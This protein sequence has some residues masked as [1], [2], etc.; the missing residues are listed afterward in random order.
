M[1]RD[2]MENLKRTMTEKNA[3]AR[4]LAV[5][6]GKGG[7]GKTNI[8]VNLAICLAASGQRVALVDA[9]MGLG[10]LDIIMNLQSRYNISHVISGQKQLDQITCIGPGDVEVICGASGLESLA[11]LT[12]FQRQRLADELDTFQDNYDLM[13]IDTAAGLSAS[14]VGF[15][16]AADHTLVVTTPEPTAMTDAY[17]MI[18]VLAGRDY[19]GKISL[20]VN[21]ADSV[22]EGKR[23][24]RQIADVARRFLNIHVYEAAVLCRDDRLPAA[25]RQRKPVVLAYPKAPITSA[26]TAMTARLSKGSAATTCREGFFRKVVNW[27]F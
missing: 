13:V 15:C 9:D 2:T 27:F 6:S 1:T 24:Y 4:V 12:R 25:V 7:V 26:I 18:K 19:S 11:D 10:N 21:M 22:A 3:R 5:T 20:I 16:H 8:S 14:V 17:A 23:I